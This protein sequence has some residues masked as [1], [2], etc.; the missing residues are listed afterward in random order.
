M[1]LA[2]PM[3]KSDLSTIMIL[4]SRLSNIYL[5]ISVESILVFNKLIDPFLVSMRVNFKHETTNVIAEII[6]NIHRGRAFI[7]TNVK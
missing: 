4:S 6:I 7:L 1:L 2:Y 5:N 3:E